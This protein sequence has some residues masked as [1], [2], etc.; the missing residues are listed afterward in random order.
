MYNVFIGQL[1][2]AKWPKYATVTQDI[3]GTDD[4]L[5]PGWRQAIIWNNAGILLIVPFWTNFSE[6][7]IKINIFLFKKKHLQNGGHFVLASVR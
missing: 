1:I 4:G 6:I 7:L 5:S 2:E 3:I